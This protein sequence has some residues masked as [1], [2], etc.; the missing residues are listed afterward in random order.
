[1]KCLAL[2][3]DL[4]QGSSQRKAKIGIGA[5]PERGVLGRV[6]PPRSKISLKPATINT[7]KA[8]GKA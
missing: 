3:G 8:K 4:L 7:G 5:K 2:K 6:V 1:L